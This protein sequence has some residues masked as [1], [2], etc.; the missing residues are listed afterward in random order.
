M[1]E[2]QRMKWIIM[3]LLM[4]LAIMMV[5]CYSLLVMASR[6]DEREEQF[7]KEWKEKDDERGLDKEV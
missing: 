7:Y 5:I 2:E 3:V 6:A 4:V 1:M